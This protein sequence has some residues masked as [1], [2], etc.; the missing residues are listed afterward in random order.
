MDTPSLFLPS[1]SLAPS[2]AVSSLILYSVPYLNT[3][4]TLLPRLIL[5]GIPENSDLGG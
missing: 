3:L 1:T 5:K 2:T 4:G